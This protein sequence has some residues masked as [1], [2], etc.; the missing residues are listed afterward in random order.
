M[1]RIRTIKPEFPQSESMGNV[2]RDARGH[3]VKKAIPAQVRRS[4]AKR[5]G[6]PPGGEVEAKCAYCSFVGSIRWFVQPTDR[7][8]GWV[9]FS[10]LELDH[11]EAELHGG[12][13]SQDNL[14]LACR[15]CNRSKGSKGVAEWMGGAHA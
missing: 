13:S 2:S 5:Y 11:V 15:G 1:A 8:S 6:C 4:I 14:T 10:G 3:F 7:G 9:A 12:P